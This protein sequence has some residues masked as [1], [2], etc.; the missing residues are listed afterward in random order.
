MRRKWRYL[1]IF[2]LIAAF[3]TGCEG[4]QEKDAGSSNEVSTETEQTEEE[5]ETPAEEYETGT[6]DDSD[7]E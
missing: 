4:D 6:F 1:A 5:T 7:F 2:A 3:C